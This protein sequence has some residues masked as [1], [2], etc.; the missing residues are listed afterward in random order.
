MSA[1]PFESGWNPL[2]ASPLT[3]YGKPRGEVIDTTNFAPLADPSGPMDIE[4]DFQ[5]AVEQTA[6]GI[7]DKARI[8]AKEGE[9]VIDSLARAASTIAMA[10]SQR[11]LLNIQLERARQGKAPLD[12]SQYG[13]GVNV[14]LSPQTILLIGGALL[15]VVL[16]A[17]RR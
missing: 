9:S 3:G 12:S 14:G 13:L 16:L 1:Q 8:M 10:D 5:A 7:M 17:R 15:A 4:M 11:R 6:P 2:M